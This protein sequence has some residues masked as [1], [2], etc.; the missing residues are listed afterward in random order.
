MTKPTP[1]RL[2]LSIFGGA[3]AI[4]ILA[5]LMPKPPAPPPEPA[6]PAPAPAP[7]SPSPAPA[8]P[9]G[10]NFR[11]ALPPEDPQLR[12]FILSDGFLAGFLGNVWIGY[13]DRADLLKRGFYLNA[14]YRHTGEGEGDGATAK[15]ACSPIGFNG[16]YICGR[17]KMAAYQW[18]IQSDQA[19]KV[20]NELEERWPSRS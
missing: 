9:I 20:L 8:A 2:G 17:G 10:Q 19:I 7:E 5:L 13:A 18:G 4:F 6:A 3:A 12:A 1:N 16:A 15:G 11:A 14:L